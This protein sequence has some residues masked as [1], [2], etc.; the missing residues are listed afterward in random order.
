MIEFFV[1]VGVLFL[2][3]WIWRKVIAPLWRSAVI[4]HQL[5]QGIIT[6]QPCFVDGEHENTN[7]V[8]RKLPTDEMQAYNR[9]TLGNRFWA[10]HKYGTDTGLLITQSSPFEALNLKVPGMYFDTS[11][12]FNALNKDGSHDF[13]YLILYYRDRWQ[14]K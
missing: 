10:V 7:G 12:P 1:L 2:A 5:S 13:A 4:R 14:F 3:T 11:Y 9:S 8:I 6:L